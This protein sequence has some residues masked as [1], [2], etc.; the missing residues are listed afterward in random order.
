[1]SK[2][3]KKK[4]FVRHCVRLLFISFLIFVKIEA[5]NDN[6]LN[7]YKSYHSGSSLGSTC[8]KYA[9]NVGCQ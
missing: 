6:D 5:T 9:S 7:N 2:F 4:K 8:C 3:E 1:M